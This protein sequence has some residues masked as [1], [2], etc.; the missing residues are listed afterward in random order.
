MGVERHGLVLRAAA[1]VKYYV[2]G[3][4]TLLLGWTFNGTTTQFVTIKFD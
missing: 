2:D 4:Q 3:I 1:V